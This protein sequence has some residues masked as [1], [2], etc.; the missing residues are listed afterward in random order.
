[1]VSRHIIPQAAMDVCIDFLNR[2]YAPAVSELFCDKLTN[3]EYAQAIAILLQSLD[4]KDEKGFPRGPRGLPSERL[5]V[6]RVINI[7]AAQVKG[8]QPSR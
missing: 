5:T 7:L 8:S 4:V 6:T 2:T 1:M 3:S